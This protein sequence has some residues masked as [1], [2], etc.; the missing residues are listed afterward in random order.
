M[1]EAMACGKPVIT[2]NGLKDIVNGGGITV[3]SA[4][5]EELKDAIYKIFSNINLAKKIGEIGRKKVKE[6]WSW[7]II[8]KKIDPRI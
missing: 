4:N 2:T 6:N 7:E 1:L 3:E 5:A 8:S